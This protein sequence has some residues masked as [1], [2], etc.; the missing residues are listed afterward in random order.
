M[1]V[2]PAHWQKNKNPKQQNQEGDH[3]NIENSEIGRIMAQQGQT[4]GIPQRPKYAQQINKKQEA[5]QRNRT[6]S[7]NKLEAKEQGTKISWE[8]IVRRW[9]EEE[10][11]VK[12]LYVRNWK[13]QW[14]VI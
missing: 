4:K 13:V 8:G 9:E 7:M 12:E 10:G 5:K 1:T 2:N 3:P 14:R 11:V 6:K